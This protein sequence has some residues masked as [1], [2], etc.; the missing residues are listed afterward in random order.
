LEYALAAEV[1]EAEALEPCTLAKARTRSDWL[2][3]ENTIQEELDMLHKAGTWTLE[4]APPGA[5]VIGSKWVFKAKK[6]AAGK[7]VRCK[8]CL[9]TQGFS[10]VPG[11]DYFDTYAPVAKLPLIQAILAIVNHQNM[12]LHQRCVP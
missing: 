9:V 5:N 1:S 6:D 4:E 7:V 2:L 11:V 12:E 8:A 3:W 10:Q